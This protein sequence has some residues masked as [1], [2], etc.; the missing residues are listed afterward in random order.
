MYRLQIAVIVLIRTQHESNQILP[1][2][3]IRPSIHP[4]VGYVYPFFYP[5]HPST[6]LYVYPTIYLFNNPFIR[7]SIHPSIYPSVHPFIYSSSFIPSALIWFVLSN[8]VIA[9]SSWVQ[10]IVREAYRH[11][12]RSLTSFLTLFLP[13]ILPSLGLSPSFLVGDDSFVSIFALC[14]CMLSLS[15]HGHAV[16]V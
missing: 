7:P 10:I 15:F 11:D 16:L 4:S 12:R 2:F 5:D 13:F 1:I 9:T 8:F 3:H 14:C 6:H